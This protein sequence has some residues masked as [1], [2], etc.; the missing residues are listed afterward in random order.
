MIFQL[1]PSV[2]LCI[3]LCGLPASSAFS[4]TGPFGLRWGMTVEDVKAQA[5]VVPTNERKEGNFISYRLSSV[6]SPVSIAEQYLVIFHRS[7]GL[8]KAT[9]VSKDFT[10]DPTGRDGKETYASIKS[11]LIAKYGQPKTEFESTGNRLYKEVDEFYQCLRY[12]GCGAWASFWEPDE[13][14]GHI[15]LQL[16][17]TGRGVGYL[18]IG[19]ESRNWNQ[20]VDEEKASKR[21]NDSKGL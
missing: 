21:A 10:G 15:A 20:L 18:T 9:L 14:R 16:R 7:T 17:G 8:Q 12:S 13:T 6:P 1:A 5:N 4:Q 2:S 19:Y 3:A 11:A